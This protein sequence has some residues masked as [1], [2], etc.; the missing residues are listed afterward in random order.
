MIIHIF[1][2]SYRSLLLFVLLCELL[3]HRLIESVVLA[4]SCKLLLL[5]ELGAQRH[6]HEKLLSYNA[7]ASSV[8]MHMIIWIKYAIWSYASIEP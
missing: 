7:H 2:H 8:W 1:I 4:L 3:Q 6:F 5:Q